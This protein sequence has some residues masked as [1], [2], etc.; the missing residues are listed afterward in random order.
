MHSFRHPLG[1]IRSSFGFH[2]GFIRVS[3]G[4]H[5]SFIRAPF[6]FH[7]GFIRPSFG[8][9]SGF[10]SGIIETVLSVKI[11]NHYPFFFIQGVWTLS[12]QRRLFGLNASYGRKN[13]DFQGLLLKYKESKP[14]CF[15]N[16]QIFS[17]I[18]GLHMMY[19]RWH[20][21]QYLQF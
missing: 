1:T 4:F 18:V 12:G 10:D 5:S 14:K 6:G 13:Y 11:L 15:Q 3:F 19:F 9:H 2:S 8:I 17:F 7:S 20:H 16:A 21:N